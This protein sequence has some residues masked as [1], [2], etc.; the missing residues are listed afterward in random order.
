MDYVPCVVYDH[1]FGEFYDGE[2]SVDENSNFKKVELIIN[3]KQFSIKTYFH[4]QKHVIFYVSKTE[5]KLY[6]KPPKFFD[7]AGFGYNKNKMD[8]ET[9]LTL[10]YGL[11]TYRTGNVIVQ[12]MYEYFN[13]FTKFKHKDYIQVK[14]NGMW[15]A[16]SMKGEVVL[17]FNYHNTYSLEHRLEAFLNYKKNYRKKYGQVSM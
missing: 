8:L 13:F 7:R 1:E 4:D 3:S 10:R 16:I 9:Y 15:G 12:P 17:D 6:R 11:C 2:A 5:D 14:K